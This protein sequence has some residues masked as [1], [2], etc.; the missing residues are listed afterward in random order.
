VLG[1]EPSARQT[2]RGNVIIGST[3]ENVG[4]DK[5][6][7]AEMLAHFARGVLLHFPRLRGLQVIRTWAGLRPATP[8]NRPIIQLLDEPAGFCLA[9]GHSRRGIVYAPGTGQLVAE[10]ITGKPPYLPLEPFNLG[11]LAVRRPGADP[12]LQ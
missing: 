2:R 4:F 1:T 10:M 12:R 3:V 9:V 8:D 6:V 11:R 5:R 7:T